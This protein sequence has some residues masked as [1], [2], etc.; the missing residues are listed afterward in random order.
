M[1]RQQWEDLAERAALTFAQGA[2]ASVPASGVISDWESLTMALTA[3][4]VGGGG[5]V[6]SMVQSTMRARRAAARG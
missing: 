4:A 1:T 6:L 3:M 2:L 5:A